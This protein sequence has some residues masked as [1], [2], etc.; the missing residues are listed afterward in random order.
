MRLPNNAVERAVRPGAAGPG[1][2]GNVCTLG[3]AARG[4]RCSLRPLSGTGGIGIGLLL[5]AAVGCAAPIARS[6][7]PAAPARS[8]A[9]SQRAEVVRVAKRYLGVP[10]AWGGESPSGFDCSGLVMYVYSKVGI[11]VP[12]SVTKQ[13]THGTPVSKRD[14]QPGDLVFFDRLRHNGIYIGGGEFIHAAR[15]GR[16]VQISRLDEDWFRTRWVGARRL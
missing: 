5:L 3:S 9:A 8:V 2:G 13:Y 4:S 11:A 10:Y 1:R 15:S 16:V 6:E 14:L 12:H 7:K